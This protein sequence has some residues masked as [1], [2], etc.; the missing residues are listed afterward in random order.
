[1]HSCATGTAAGISLPLDPSHDGHRRRRRGGLYP[2]SVRGTHRARLSVQR[3]PFP[4][5]GE[6]TATRRLGEALRSAA[7]TGQRRPHGV[8]R[9]MDHLIRWWIGKGESSRW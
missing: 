2:A 4:K 6:R 5:A 9:V 3:T 8:N 1:V 7:A